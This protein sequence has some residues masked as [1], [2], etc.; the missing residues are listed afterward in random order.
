MA[1]TTRGSRL[2]HK[3]GQ[4][5]YVVRLRKDDSV[6]ACGNSLQCA[7]AM[8]MNLESFYSTVTRCRNGTNRRYL[9]DIELWEEQ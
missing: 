6:I 8:G 4:K 7:K 1:P 5:F 9:I 2:A 3:G